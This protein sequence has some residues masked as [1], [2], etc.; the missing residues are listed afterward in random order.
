MFAGPAKRSQL[1]QVSARDTGQ[2]NRTGYCPNRFWEHCTWSALGQA[3]ITRRTKTKHVNHTYGLA[4]AHRAA[5]PTA[6][7]A[8]PTSEAELP[9]VWWVGC[10][11]S[12]DGIREG[13]GEGGGGEGGG[14]RRR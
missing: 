4:A 3:A 7:K 13:K 6:T 14:R 10:M 5:Q 12:V 1:C 11:W 9:G 2:D 8:Q